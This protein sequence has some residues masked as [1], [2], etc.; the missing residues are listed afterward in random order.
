M[1]LPL[2]PDLIESLLAKYHRPYHKR[3]SNLAN[4]GVILGIDCHTM[5]QTGPPVGPDP[6][7]RRPWV[8]LGNAHNATCPA[9]WIESLAECFS[10]EFFNDVSINEPFAGGYITRRHGEEILWI[11]L[12]LSRDPMINDGEKAK[13]ILQ[14]L[15]RWYKMVGRVKA[16]L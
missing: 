12:E 7:L 4:K 11:Q 5:A 8:C 9:D 3:L 14:A 16:S 2:T 13:R 10:T 15:T 6:G 1:P